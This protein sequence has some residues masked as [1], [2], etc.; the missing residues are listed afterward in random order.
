ME[1]H[2]AECSGTTTGAAMQTGTG[3]SRPLH[4]CLAGQTEPSWPGPSAYTP[5]WTRT[6]CWAGGRCLSRGTWHCRHPRIWSEQ[7]WSW[8]WNLKDKDKPTSCHSHSPGRDGWVPIRT[9][10]SQALG[11]LAIGKSALSA[12]C[13]QLVV[14]VEEY[15]EGYRF[16]RGSSFLWLMEINFFESKQ[17]LFVHNCAPFV[18]PELSWRGRRAT[19][20]CSFLQGTAESKCGQFDCLAGLPQT[21][22]NSMLIFQNTSLTGTG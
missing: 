1:A 21:L 5:P 16:W 22:L 7:L 2:M 13:G 12:G 11:S 10:Y 9:N 8:I 17:T 4:S 15:L 18:T 6:R 19:W 14:N 20:S 3:G